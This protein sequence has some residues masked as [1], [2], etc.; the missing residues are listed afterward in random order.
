MTVLHPWRLVSSALRRVHTICFRGKKSRLCA[1]HLVPAGLLDLMAWM[2]GALGTISISAVRLLVGRTC[3]EALAA[4][5][6][7]RQG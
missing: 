1:A 5:R 2:E 4:G 6:K 7:V 3:S